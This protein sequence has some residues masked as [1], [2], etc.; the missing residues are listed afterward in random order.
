MRVAIDVDADWRNFARSEIRSGEIAV[1]QAIRTA[2][3]TLVEIWRQQIMQAGLGQRLANSIRDQSY[4]RG[5]P[6]LNAATIVYTKAPKLIGSFERGAVIQGKT[7][8]WLA[9]PTKF[10]GPRRSRRNK[11]TPIDFERR[12]G[13]RL[14]MVM[15]TP[16]RAM[17][18]AD[19]SRVSSKGFA[20]A[21][22]RRG[23]RAQYDKKTLPIFILVPQARIAKRLNLIAA[24][25]R[26]TGPIPQLIIANWD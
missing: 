6:S 13:L 8:N 26:V 15:V 20:R 14:R 7:G 4:P 3:K 22:R 10:A 23:R 25:G 16:N 11:L 5:Q 19:G 24:T 17:L 9:I 1:T 2:G 21:D 18:V 12:T